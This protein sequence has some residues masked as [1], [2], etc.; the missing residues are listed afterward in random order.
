MSRSFKNGNGASGSIGTIPTKLTVNHF[1]GRDEEPEATRSG[2]KN[3]EPILPTDTSKATRRQFTLADKQRILRLAD[4]CSDQRQIGALLR[5]EGMYQCTLQRFITERDGARLASDGIL[6]SHKS[7]G[8]QDAAAL[9][10]KVAELERQNASL[11]TKLRKAEIVIDFQK[12][13]SQLLSL[14]MGDTT[15]SDGEKS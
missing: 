8:I 1:S 10:I 4:A 12:K 11:T 14:E 15:S 9:K 13:L 7:N 3:A 6:K 2:Q 5:R